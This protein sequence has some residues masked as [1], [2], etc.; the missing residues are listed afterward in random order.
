MCVS[1]YDVCNNVLAKMKQIHSKARYTDCMCR[2]P[3][4]T[5]EGSVVCFKAQ[6]CRI[7]NGC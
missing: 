4:K 3:A 5:G 6:D 7:C 1:V 2:V